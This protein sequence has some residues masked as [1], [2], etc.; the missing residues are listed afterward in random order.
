MLK[1][2][3]ITHVLQ[4]GWERFGLDNIF[5]IIFFYHMDSVL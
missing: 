3:Y 5:Q 2:K 4:F 1:L